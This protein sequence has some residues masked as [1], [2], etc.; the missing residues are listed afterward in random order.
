MFDNFFNRDS[1]LLWLCRLPSYPDTPLYTAQTQTG[2]SD[3]NDNPK[4]DFP[5][6]VSLPAKPKNRAFAECCPGS[7][8]KGFSCT[9]EG[10]PYKVPL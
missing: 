5:E 9:D 6:T 3:E 1:R 10:V 2:T 8:S 4:A 7:I